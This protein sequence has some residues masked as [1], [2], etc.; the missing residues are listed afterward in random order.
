[1][2]AGRLA[3]A[4]PNLS[5]L[6]IEQGM[7]NY[8]IP[9]VIYPALFPVNLLPD[10]KTALF[11]QGNQSEALDN[12]APVIPS[13]GTLGGGSSINW[14]VYTR[15]QRS[16]FDSWN[17]P[18]W[19]ANDLYPYLRKFETYH[20][21]GEREHHGY[22]GPI[23]ISSGTFRAKR[24]EGD[25]INAAAKMGYGELK[26]LQNLDANNATGRWLR[27]VGPDGRRQSAAD[28]Y[29]HPKL[30]SGGYPNLHVLC[31]HQVV[32]ILIDGNKRAIGVELQP[33]PKFQSAG[34]TQNVRANKMVIV[35]AGANGTPLM[36]E[37][38][39]IGD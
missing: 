26:D 22:E 25:F 30:N 20:G 29:L 19:T 27:Y 32:R 1:M 14:M 10:S 18:G 15:A 5:I 6:V 7:N 34:P 38:S 8:N 23:N 2:I 21:P 3:E 35:S 37:R 16:D 17:T 9:E 39:G 4:D 28:R 33:N 13:G 36:L 31:E 11:W 24:A 12:R